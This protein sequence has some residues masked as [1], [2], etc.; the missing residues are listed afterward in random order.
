[1]KLFLA[2]LSVLALAM[3]P[4]A[5]ADQYICQPTATG[6]A[7]VRVYTDNGW[8]YVAACEYDAAHSACV[9][10]GH[11]DYNPQYNYIA[12]SVNAGVCANAVACVSTVD[13]QYSWA[14]DSYGETSTGV[15]T[16]AGYANVGAQAGSDNGAPD[17]ET[18]FISSLTGVTCLAP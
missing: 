6:N 9:G 5:A 15:W 14:G 2:T 12:N 1:M 17:A 13:G 7:C 4:T 10:G 18:C 3:I 11:V 8:A 16:V